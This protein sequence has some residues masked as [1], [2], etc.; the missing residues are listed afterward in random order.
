MEGKIVR[1][2]DKIAYI[3]SDIDDAI[4]AGILREEE[5][6][7]R[8]TDILG[9]STNLRLNTLVHDIVKNSEGKNDICMSKEVEEAMKEL[10]GYMFQRVYTNPVAK[11]EEDKVDNLIGQLYE[12]YIHNIEKMPLEFL[13]LI[14]G[15]EPEERV[16]CDFIACMS[17]RYAVNLYKDIMI[18]KSWS[19]HGIEHR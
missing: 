14:D 9:K 10:R 3:N 8:L 18:P 12:H 6:P 13:L 2:S 15:G 17:D 19:V 5:I 4:R 1:L 11:S 7:S 16:V